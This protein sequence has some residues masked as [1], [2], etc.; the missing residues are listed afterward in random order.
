LRRRGTAGFTLLELTIVLAVI[1]IVM[2]VA[3][4][5][6]V[7]MVR[8][9]R[10]A[11]AIADLYAVRAAAY[12]YFGHHGSWPAE[13][14]TGDVPR[15]LVPYLPRGFSFRRGAYTLDWDN[16]GLGRGRWGRCSGNGVAIGI[17]MIT[18]DRKL[19]AVVQGLL[20]NAPFIQTSSR[21]YTLQISSVYGF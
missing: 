21:V 20:R 4:P 16:W 13:V 8:E 1:A 15:E 7:E 5:T 17:S 18:P 9:T 6:Y 12:L 2:A 3:I 11:E 10:A 19:P 14:A